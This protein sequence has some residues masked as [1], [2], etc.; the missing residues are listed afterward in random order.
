MEKPLGTTLAALWRRGGGLPVG[1]RCV[2]YPQ[3]RLLGRMAACLALAG[4][5]ETVTIT[6]T[7]VQVDTVVVADTIRPEQDQIAFVSSRDGDAD[8][9]VMDADGSNLHSLMN[10]QG[11]DVNPRWS[12]DGSRIAFES[13]R[14]GN[15]EVNRTGIVGGPRA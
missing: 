11:T 2:R 8:I 9:F 14:D 6:E 15:H 13:D 4:C 12:P 10:A 7:L 5:T 3:K 1:L